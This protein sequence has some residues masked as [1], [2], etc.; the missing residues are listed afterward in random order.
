ML[1]FQRLEP[2][3]LSRR[4]VDS[5][6]VRLLI[7]ITLQELPHQHLVQHHN[8]KHQHLSAL[9]DKL[10]LHP[11]QAMALVPQWPVNRAPLPFL[12][13]TAVPDLLLELSKAPSAPKSLVTKMVPTVFRLLLPVRPPMV[14]LTHLHLV[15]R[16]LSIKS[17]LSMWQS[18]NPPTMVFNKMML[19]RLQKLR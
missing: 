5:V 6:A 11:P 10:H 18:H 8:P 4:L 2:L 16:H 13:K 1:L 3:S 12:N 9:N 14:K 15:F 17:S 19:L 7:G